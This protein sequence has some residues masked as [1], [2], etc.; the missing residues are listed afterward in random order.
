VKEFY[1][2]LERRDPTER[3]ADLFRRLPSVL[4]AAMAGPAYAERLR[5]IDPAAITDRA[6]PSGRITSIF[7]PS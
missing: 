4:C 7:S 6:A 1:D 5:G 3:E 2:S